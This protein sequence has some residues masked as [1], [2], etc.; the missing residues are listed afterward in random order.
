VGGRKIG[1][2]RVN[3][4]LKERGWD[5][6]DWTGLVWVRTGTSGMLLWTR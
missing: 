4:D 5:G 1:L 3:I 6:M 2:E